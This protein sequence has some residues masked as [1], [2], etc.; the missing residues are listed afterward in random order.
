MS[1]LSK[2]N[3]EAGNTR[4]ARR[5]RAPPPQRVIS[6]GVGLIVS[7]DE[8]SVVLLPGTGDHVE[9]IDAVEEW[10]G[11]RG[12]P[13]P[14]E[15]GEESP[16]QVDTGGQY[17]AADAALDIIPPVAARAKTVL[18]M[19]GIWRI[20]RATRE[21]L[22]ESSA[23]GSRKTIPTFAKNVRHGNSISRSQFGGHTTRRYLAFPSEMSR[24]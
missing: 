17:D 23:G 21:D 24:P 16:A 20:R 7:S 9:T 13:P 11:D 18:E 10:M 4:G 15:R 14:I 8:D 2:R 1:P 6:I 22:D 3:M 12:P 19:P 5:C